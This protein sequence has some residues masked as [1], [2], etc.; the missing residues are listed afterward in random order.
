MALAEEEAMKRAAL[1]GMILGLTPICAPAATLETSQ[2][3]N[4]LVG[5]YSDD[6]TGQFS[7]C[8]MTASYRSGISMVF[9]VG[10]DFQW[11]AGF[12]DPA[13]QLAVGAKYPLQLFIDGR[14]PIPAEATAIS[15]QLVSVPLAA[16]QSLFEKF[17]H[18]YQ[19]RVNA[20]G[21]DFLFNLDGTARGLSAV[22]SCTQKYVV[23]AQPSLSTN[24]FVAPAT[25]ATQ[26]AGTADRNAIK[27]EAT[28]FAANLLSQAGIV[29]FKILGP[30]EVPKE[31]QTFDVVWTGPG[32]AG[33]VSVVLPQS[34]LGLDDIRSGLISG[35]ARGCKGKF[36]S[37]SMPDEPGQQSVAQLFTACELPST[38]TVAYYSVLARDAGGFYVFGIVGVNASTDTARTA[39]AEIR[40]AALRKVQ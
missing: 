27:A 9:A 24:P 30:Q 28:A 13:W 15:P 31:W 33:T 18:G 29:G 21:Q 19:L 17:R 4:W 6:R 39:E 37:G 14:G 40:D 26:S 5:A 11:S 7:H 35:D 10:S 32:L 38:H 22:L 23:A 16:N 34:K 1:I 8:A 25:P 20:V 12:A 3:G 36:A 2:S